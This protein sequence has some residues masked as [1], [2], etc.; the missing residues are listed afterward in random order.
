MT[1]KKYLSISLLIS[2]LVLVRPEFCLA[3][4]KSDS[5]ILDDSVKDISVVLAA[6]AAGAVLGLSTLS[7]V[8]HP[9]DHMKNIA[10]GGAIGIVIGV[11]YVIFSQATRSTSAI[12][13][14]AQ[15]PV[16][17]E[18]FENLTRHEFSEVKIAQSRLRPTSLG[19]SFSF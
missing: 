19:F 3:Q 18:K 6:G 8:E 1:V 11:G 4:S 16:N 14:Q 10:V 17:A 13:T 9:S 7:F 15:V 2:A 12:A 5:D